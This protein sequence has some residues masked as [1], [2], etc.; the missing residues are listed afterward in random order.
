MGVA[1]AV[2]ALAVGLGDTVGALAS[3]VLATGVSCGDSAV[4]AQAAPAIN[5]ATNVTTTSARFIQASTLQP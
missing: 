3:A 4:L 1:E 2:V 5:A